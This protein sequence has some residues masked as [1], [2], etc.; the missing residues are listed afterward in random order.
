MT[1]RAACAATF[2]TSPTASI[3][4]WRM[5]SSGTS[6]AGLCA[7]CILTMYRN[8][9]KHSSVSALHGSLGGSSSPRCT[10][11]RLFGTHAAAQARHCSGAGLKSP[12]SR[13]R[14]KPRLPATS[15][16]RSES[17]SLFSDS[18]DSFAAAVAAS[19]TCDVAAT[20]GVTLRSLNSGR[21]SPCAMPARSAAHSVV[22]THSRCG[23][24]GSAPAALGGG[25]PFLFLASSLLLFAPPP[26]FALPL[27]G[28][29]PRPPYDRTARDHSTSTVASCNAPASSPSSGFHPA[30]SRIS[31]SASVAFSAYGIR[32]S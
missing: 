11:V 31:P 1:H 29:A 22:S 24:G 16:G 13:A 23:V 20:A 12:W 15:D 32:P 17:S 8:S 28:L 3:S 5:T 30:R 25:G 26:F 27:T 14:I 9:S 6:G 2:S 21:F 7:P 18:V 10:A 19:M 4:I